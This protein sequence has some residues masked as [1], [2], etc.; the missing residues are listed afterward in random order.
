M[1]MQQVT[2]RQQAQLT[3]KPK[4]GEEQIE[5]KPTKKSNK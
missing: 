4:E 1:V 2:Q 3:S 5:T